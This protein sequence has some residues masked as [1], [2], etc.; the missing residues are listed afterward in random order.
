MEKDNSKYRFCFIDYMWYVVEVWHE[1]EH[2]NLNGRVL[3]FLCWLLV[4]LIPLGIP[5]LLRFFGWMIALVIVIPL[6][7]LPDLFCKI[8]YTT[9][10]RNAVRERYGK[11]KHPGRK[12]AGITLVAIALAL[13]NVMLVFHLGFMHWSR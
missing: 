1:K 4:I 13:A 9:R 11:M 3:L 10:Q 5:L 7:F 6:C 8:R 12:L 2:T